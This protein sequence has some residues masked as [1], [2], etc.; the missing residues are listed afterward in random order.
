ME[1][2]VAG[3]SHRRMVVYRYREWKIACDISTRRRTRIRAA[4]S[5]KS[6]LRLKIYRPLMFGYLAKS[7]GLL[8]IQSGDNQFDSQ[9]AI[10]G[11]HPQKIQQ[12]LDDQLL[13]EKIHNNILTSTYLQ[14]KDHD[15]R[16]AHFPDNVDQLHF[17]CQKIITDLKWLKSLFGLFQAMLDRMVTIGVIYQRPIS[18]HLSF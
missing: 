4:F 7:L 13:K 18:S 14:I 5:V 9:F 16:L 11:N 12:L 1:G 3:V 2:E 6:D 17:Q 8:G 10:Q 15:H